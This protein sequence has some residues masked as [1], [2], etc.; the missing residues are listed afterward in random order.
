MSGFSIGGCSPSLSAAK[1]T[2]RINFFFALIPE[3]SNRLKKRFLQ[4]FMLM[5]VA[6]VLGSCYMPIRFD[7]EIEL[8]RRGYYEF[9]FDGYLA[10]VALYD[11]LRKREISRDEEKKQAKDIE[12]DFRRDKSTKDF[13]YFK[14]GHFYVKWTRKGDL[15]KAKTVTFIRR[16]E[17]VLSISYNNKTGR[18]SIAG[19]SI[20]RDTKRQLAEMGL[21]ITGEIRVITDTKVISHNA[22]GVKKLPKRGPGFKM[23]T[24]KIKNI[25]DRTPSLITSLR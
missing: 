9:F 20:R 17:Q 3:M 21:N 2:F 25:F 18:V 15:T 10:K 7:A 4:P 19:R 8:S 23:Y 14:K 16:N 22:T 13:K 1:I 11:G 12:T 5:I 24:W 6:V